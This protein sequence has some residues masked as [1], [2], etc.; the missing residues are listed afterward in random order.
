MKQAIN[1][2]VTSYLPSSVNIKIQFDTDL[3]YLSVT[4]GSFAL[5]K[6]GLYREI[7]LELHFKTIIK[8]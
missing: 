5:I 6:C 2:Q 1:K 4:I 3:H 7:A 8:F